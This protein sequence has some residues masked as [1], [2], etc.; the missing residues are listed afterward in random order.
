MTS[1]KWQKETLQISFINTPT[2]LILR[3]RTS[4]VLPYTSSLLLR[5]WIA[6]GF[7]P[8]N[9]RFSTNILNLSGA[10]W[11]IHD[12]DPVYSHVQHALFHTG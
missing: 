9:F 3:L 7:N 4:N 2:V 1:F 12:E 11:L 5:F 10:V 6:L 8:I